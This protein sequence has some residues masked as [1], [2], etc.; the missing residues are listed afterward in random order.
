MKK[1]RKRK[2]ELYIPAGMKNK[3]V[4]NAKKVIVLLLI[5]AMTVPITSYA[6]TMNNNGIIG[7]YD[8]TTSAYLSGKDY[9]RSFYAVARDN[10]YRSLFCKVT[11][12]AYTSSNS[13]L[14]TV[15]GTASA[16]GTLSI[17]CT[18]NGK[19]NVSPH[20]ATS[21]EEFFGSNGS[22]PATAFQ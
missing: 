18:A 22:L 2:Y 8:C 17:S 6:G 13:I 11:T 1:E 21:T 9:G 4:S 7:P 10:T 5:C 3:A 15:S 19:V 20:H 14:G 16:S 12:T